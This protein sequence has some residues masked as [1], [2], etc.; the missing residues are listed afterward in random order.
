M[1]VVNGGR[2]LRVNGPLVECGGIG[3]PAI[4][5]L[6]ALGE[7]EVW[8]EVV[9]VAGDR[10]TVQAYEDTGGLAP[11]DRARSLRR[12]LSARLGPGL[13]GQVFDGLLRPLSAAPTF[14]DR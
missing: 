2:L 9:S 4:A 6:V 11:G 1:D 5:E 10:A 8:G 13:L 7:R 3:N 12:P 14:L